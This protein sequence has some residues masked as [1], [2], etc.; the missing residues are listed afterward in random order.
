MHVETVWPDVVTDDWC[1]EW[2]KS[3]ENG[4]APIG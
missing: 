4:E 1:G 3:E 2:Q